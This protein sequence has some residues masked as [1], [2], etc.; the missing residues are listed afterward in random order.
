MKKKF[1]KLL[2]PLL[3]TSGIVLIFIAILLMIQKVEEQLTTYNSKDLS[4]YQYF[5]DRR[6]DYNTTIVISNKDNETSL[7]IDGE[8]VE[9]DSTPFYYQKERK[10]LFPKV[11]SVIFPM[12]NVL[13]K[14]IPYFQKLDGTGTSTYIRGIHTN[15]LLQ[16]AFLY[17]GND[18]YF[19]PEGVKVTIMGQEYSMSNFS[20]IIVGFDNEV[21]M[22]DYELD[23]ATLLEN[24]EGDV[25]AT[26]N[27]CKIN[28]SIDSV[29][30]NGKSRLLL[31]NLDYL[32]NLK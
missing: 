16:N 17:D 7:K 29:I 23:H 20:Y 24:V 26:Y 3:V 14:K 8:T 22:Y 6:M 11:M 5:K 25:I 13:Q 18:L 1:K 10:V 21:I 4:L 32:D 28:L 19:F 9:L 12:S 15:Y 30:Y 31:K 27:D 2:I